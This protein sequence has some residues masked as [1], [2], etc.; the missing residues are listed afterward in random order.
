MLL[1]HIMHINNINIKIK[2]KLDIY[3]YL[4]LCFYDWINWWLSQWTGYLKKVFFVVF[5]NLNLMQ[6]YVNLFVKQ[7]AI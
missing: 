7:I 5:A 4:I 2:D 6:I 3:F 1:M